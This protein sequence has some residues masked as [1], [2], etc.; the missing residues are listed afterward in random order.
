MITR[1]TP[2]GLGGKKSYKCACGKRVVRQRWFEQTLNPYNR[3]ADGSVKTQ[4]Q[5]M[6]ECSTAFIAWQ[7]KPEPCAHIRVIQQTAGEGA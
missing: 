3:N 2:V 1:F 6:A 7:K 5:I 4:G